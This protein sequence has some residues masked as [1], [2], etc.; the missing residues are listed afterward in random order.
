MPTFT[1]EIMVEASTQRVF[2]ALTKPEMITLGSTDE[3]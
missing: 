3:S 2:D 1:A